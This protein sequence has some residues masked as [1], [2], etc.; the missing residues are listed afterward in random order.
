MPDPV[1]TLGLLVEAAVAI[2]GF[3]GVVVVFGRRATGEWS[4]LERLRIGNLVSA[5]FSVLFLSLAILL[6][7]HIGIAAATT[8]RAG[9]AIWT[10]VA[11]RQLILVS[12]IYRTLQKD[13]QR[14]RVTMFSLQLSVASV[15]IA[16]NV[17]NTL[18]LGRFWP[19]FAAQVFL[20]GVACYSFASLLLIQGRAGRTA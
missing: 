12:R 7:L 1:E 11:V 2:A 8:W 3:S 10:A 17:W 6:L 9:S 20:F 13:P 5:S 16:L 14:P 4:G 15:V 18:V 19:F